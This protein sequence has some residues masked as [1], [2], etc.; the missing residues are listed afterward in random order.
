M[1]LICLLLALLAVLSGCWSHQPARPRAAIVESRQLDEAAWPA[2]DTQQLRTI[3]E[4]TPDSIHIW[5]RRDGVEESALNDAERQLIAPTNT[6]AYK[7]IHARN[8]LRI[9]KRPDSAGG[10]V[11]WAE[12]GYLFMGFQPN[13][14]I[15]SSRTLENAAKSEALRANLAPPLRV[16]LPAPKPEANPRIEPLDLTHLHLDE[17]LPVYI[18][19]PSANPVRGVI[20]HLQSLGANE[21]EPKVLDEFRERGWA[22]IDLKPQSYIRSPIPEAWH[23]EI[24]TLEARHRD[25]QAEV[26]ALDTRD[27]AKMAAASRNAKNHPKYAE[28]ERVFKR[29]SKLRKGGY[30]VCTDADVSKVA[31][32]IAWEVDQGMAGC[33]YA[34]ESILDYIDTQRP[35]LQNKPVVLMG[36]SAGAL[37]TPTSAAWIEARHPGRISAVVLIAGGCDLLKITR[38]SSFHDGGVRI[39]CGEEPVDKAVAA[40]VNDLY[41]ASSR[42]DPYHTA[43]MIAHLPILQV[44]ASKDTWVPKATGEMLYERLGGP[45]RLNLS[46]DHDVLFYLLPGKKEWMADWVERAVQPAR[47]QATGAASEHA[48]P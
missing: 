8:L 34:V 6:V 21:Y 48:A 22:V 9:F 47:P 10:L 30:Q 16:K 23:E 45:E 4:Q 27:N 12:W 14:F 25:L 36:F 19:E 42:L 46:G 40:Q 24:R 1:P 5:R 38:E 37:A 7:G 39:I 43:P 15:V 3:L 32:E 44:H 33:A 18:P 13:G 28:M 31:K 29:W 26:Y 17:G 41:L 2:R 35:D 11:G 20:L